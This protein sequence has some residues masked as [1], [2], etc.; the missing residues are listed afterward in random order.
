MTSV[1]YYQ[2]IQKIDF[3]QSG[4][5]VFKKFYCLASGALKYT[6]NAFPKARNA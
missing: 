3:S 2:N 6:S 5:M 1:L 4:L